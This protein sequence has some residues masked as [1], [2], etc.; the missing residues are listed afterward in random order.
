MSLGAYS[1]THLVVLQLVLISYRCKS[2]EALLAPADLRVPPLSVLVEMD[3]QNTHRHRVSEEV[4]SSSSGKSGPPPASPSTNSSSSLSNYLDRTT[5]TSTVFPSTSPTLVSPPSQGPAPTRSI[6][7]S[8][9]T[10]SSTAN[11]ERTNGER[12]KRHSLRQPPPPLQPVAR[13][14]S[15]PSN[16]G[17]QPPSAGLERT[18]S[19]HSSTASVTQPRPTSP[20]TSPSIHKSLNALD[21]KAITRD[22]ERSTQYMRGDDMLTSPS[23]PTG[24]NSGFYFPPST[25]PVP[26]NATPYMRQGSI[27]NPTVPNT[28][29]SSAALNAPQGDVWQNLCVR[30]LPLFNGEGVKGNIEDLNELFRYVKHSCV[31]S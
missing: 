17:G 1:Q 26:P 8:T 4:A 3:P 27:S 20:V 5:P 10:S 29:I 7:A 12:A 31:T 6:S 23:S 19:N 28:I 25:S 30:V 14:S 2:I 9:P 22:M 18:F 11:G 24:I 21:A 16:N 13:Q 15:F